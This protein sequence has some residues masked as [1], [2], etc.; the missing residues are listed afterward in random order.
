M[1]TMMRDIMESQEEEYCVYCGEKVPQNANKCEHCGQ[2]I[3]EESVSRN[4]VY[5]NNY[6][7][8]ENN[9]EEEKNMESEDVSNKSKND[10]EN[11]KVVPT[12]K[13]KNN[14]EV[15][16]YS[17][18]IPIRRLFLLMLFTCG[19][20]GFYWYYKNSC[21]IRDELGKDVNPILMT[22]LL[23]IPIVNIVIFFI[24]L[25]DMNKFIEK[26]GIGSYSPILNTLIMV[27]LG[28]PFT[29]GMWVLIN[30]QESFNEFWRLKEPELPVRR[31]FDNVEIIAMLIITL[32]A[33]F[34]IT[35]AI[36]GMYVAYLANAMGLS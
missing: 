32:I 11:N 9:N 6:V 17:K 1:N 7:S 19:L 14:K 22:I 27:L 35:M 26:E 2:W 18:A 4:H 8:D 20:Y 13:S 10:D 31:E 34:A 23:I 25:N 21:Y 29:L 5:N 24:L 3:G 16:E 36:T 12:N 15:T 28:G 33:I 30:V